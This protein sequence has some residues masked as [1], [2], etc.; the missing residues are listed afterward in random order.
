MC[1]HYLPCDGHGGQRTILWTWSSLHLCMAS[2]N[3]TRL[4]GF[5]WKHTSLLSLLVSPASSL[6]SFQLSSSASVHFFSDT[7][8]IVSFLPLSTKSLHSILSKS[9]SN[10]GQTLHLVVWSLKSTLTGVVSCFSVS[11]EMIAFSGSVPLQ[12]IM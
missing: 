2:G 5:R 8:P 9:A 12:G 4:P 7:H 10:P 3:S 11:M 1:R 6:V